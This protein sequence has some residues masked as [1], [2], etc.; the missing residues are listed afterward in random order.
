MPIVEIRYEAKCK[1]CQFLK[2]FW[3][4]KRKFYKCSN[5]Q[6]GRDRI[7]LR[8]KSCDQFKL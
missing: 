4:G 2:P 6:S 7:T 1:H 3:E 8:D 5:D